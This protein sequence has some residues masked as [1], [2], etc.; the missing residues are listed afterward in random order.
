[1]V[2]GKSEARTKPQTFA[3]REVEL[4]CNVD[5]CPVQAAEHISGEREGMAVIVG[6]ARTFAG[7]R[8]SCSYGQASDH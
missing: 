4:W 7:A 8:L 3:Q 6:N 5:Y 2:Q 1:M